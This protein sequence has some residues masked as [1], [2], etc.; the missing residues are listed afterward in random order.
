MKVIGDRAQLLKYKTLENFAKYHPNLTS[1]QNY[2]NYYNNAFGFNDTEFVEKK[3][4]GLV[5][6]NGL[7]YLDQP[8]RFLGPNFSEEAYIRMMA[9]E[10]GRLYNHPEEDID[11]KFTPILEE[12]DRIRIMAEN[13]DI[14]LIIVGH[15]SHLQVYPE[16]RAKNYYES[17][18]ITFISIPGPE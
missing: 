17:K 3:G 6:P 10:L 12:I 4:G 1:Y 18:K 15:P 9:K 11:K 7:T 16:K 8:E 2:H 13:S 14:P 5:D